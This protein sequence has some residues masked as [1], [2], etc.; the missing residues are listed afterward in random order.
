M[1]RGTQDRGQQ[2]TVPPTDVDDCRGGA[3][4]VGGDQRRG[5]EFRGARHGVIED[6]GEFRI[7]GQVFEEGL[8]L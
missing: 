2:P 7:V 1:W 4:V 8:A 5:R 3:E 6:F